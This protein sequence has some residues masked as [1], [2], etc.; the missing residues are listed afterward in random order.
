MLRLMKEIKNAK[1]NS[2]NLS[3]DERRQ[4]AENIMNKLASL[5]EDDEYDDE[6]I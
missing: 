3:D 5:M 1:Y 4:N 6:E 2:K